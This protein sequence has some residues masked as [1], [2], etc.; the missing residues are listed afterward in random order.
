M[1]LLLLQQV[2]SKQIESEAGAALEVPCAK[3]LKRS[4]SSIIKRSAVFTYPG[5][6]TKVFTSSCSIVCTSNSTLNV[7]RIPSAIFVP[8]P[9]TFSKVRKIVFS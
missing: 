7:E 8:T 2:S 5:T 9:F 6:L 4:R 3:V 1:L